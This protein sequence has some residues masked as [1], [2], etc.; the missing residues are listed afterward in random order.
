[1]YELCLLL[2]YMV[3]E[4]YQVTYGWENTENHISILAKLSSEICY[5]LI[6]NVA[7]PWFCVFFNSM[8]V[9]SL[10][11]R[12]MFWCV[13]T[14]IDSATQSSNNLSAEH[15]LVSFHRT[16][17]KTVHALAWLDTSGVDWP[18]SRSE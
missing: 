14:K 6:N 8:F 17:L 4:I 2:V 18:C 13:D 12:A 7:C 10:Q 5:I 1:M 9:E 16:L 3:I 15:D 11:F